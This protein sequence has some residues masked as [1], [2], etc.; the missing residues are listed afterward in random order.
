MMEKTE[1]AKESVDIERS[2]IP[3]TDFEYSFKVILVGDTGVGKTSVIKRIELNKFDETHSVT[4]GGDFVKIFYWVNHQKVK[5]S[6]W[7]TCGLEQYR[8]MIKIYFKGSDAS[9]IVFDLSSEKTFYSVQKWL[10][11]VKDNISQ[12][13]YIYLVGNKSDLGI[14]AVPQEVIN[15]YVASS[16]IN[17]YYEISARTSEGIDTMFNSIVYDIYGKSLK[18]ASIEASPEDKPVQIEDGKKSAQKKKCC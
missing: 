13:S 15:S 8:S 1:M 10:A 2:T 6:L 18:E 3:L 12:S 5:V 7:D 14:R 11:D 4:L 9:I 16:G 17:G